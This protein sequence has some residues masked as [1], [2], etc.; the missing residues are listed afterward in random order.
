MKILRYALTLVLALGLLVAI[1]PGVHAQIVGPVDQLEP[2]FPGGPL[3]L[4]CA[5][6]RQGLKYTDED[7]DQIYG[8]DSYGNPVDNCV[9]VKNGDCDVDPANCDVDDSGGDPTPAELNAGDQADWDHNGTG[10]ACD[11]ADGDGVLDYLDNCKITPNA[12]QDPAACTDTDRDS[13]EDSIDNCPELYNPRQEDIDED[14]IG[15]WCDVCRF[16]FDPDQADADDDGR[17]DACPTDEGVIITVPT[18]PPDTSEG[19]EPPTGPNLER[20]SGGCNLMAVA[21]MAAPWSALGAILA[22]LALAAIRKDR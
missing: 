16:V 17:G 8:E 21:T 19:A 3:Q 9:L 7:C 18:T 1:I 4:G 6:E 15:D 12:D 20:G 11:D 2:V 14:G 5:V 10:D 13:F 22:V